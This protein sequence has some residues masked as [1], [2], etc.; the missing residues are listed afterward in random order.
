MSKAVVSPPALLTS[1]GCSR[2][3]AAC[4]INGT[5]VC[6]ASAKGSRR[7][8]CVQYMCVWRGGRAPS[9]AR[10][11]PGTESGWWHRC[12]PY[13]R[14]RGW[15]W[16]RA[17]KFACAPQKILGCDQQCDLHACALVRRR[18]GPWGHGARRGEGTW[19]AR[20]HARPPARPAPGPHCPAAR[21]VAI[22]RPAASARPGVCP[23]PLPPQ[24]ACARIFFRQEDAARDARGR[25]RGRRR[26]GTTGAR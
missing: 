5:H 10:T 23:P 14:A 16:A 18:A 4:V 2:R 12:R 24:P 22:S 21:A 20:R 7:S 8:A 13:T 1:G 26:G 11:R 15:T 3:H 17:Q 25:R 6:G 9:S 19:R